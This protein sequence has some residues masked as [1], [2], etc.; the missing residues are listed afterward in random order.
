[1]NKIL[2]KAYGRKD[3][4]KLVKKQIV[5]KRGHKQTVHVKIEDH[6]DK[7]RPLLSTQNIDYLLEMDPSKVSKETLLSALQEADNIISIES[8]QNREWNHELDLAFSRSQSKSL[9][10]L[11]KEDPSSARSLLNV[12][13]EYLQDIKEEYE[14]KD[15]EK[16]RNEL[17]KI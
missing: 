15:R 5:D 1:M 12:A 7:P 2:I 8:A 3:L 14:R 4:S 13:K 9:Y 11:V 17:S 10:T 16:S 6:P